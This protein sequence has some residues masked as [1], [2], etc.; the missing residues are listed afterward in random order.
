MALKVSSLARAVITR[1][2]S[3][4]QHGAHDDNRPSQP[5]LPV[6]PSSPPAARKSGAGQPGLPGIRDGLPRLGA[7]DAEAL[8]GLTTQLRGLLQERELTAGEILLRSGQ[9]EASA[10]G[11]Y[12]PE[13]A[14]DPIAVVLRACA[15]RNRSQRWSLWTTAV[16]AAL[17]AASPDGPIALLPSIAPA[18]TCR[19]RPK[20][21]AS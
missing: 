6:A 21:S 13:V 20:K 9:Y 15:T 5:A 10:L 11:E 16:R 17:R 18:R 1:R 19:L 7:S 14:F 2:G 12:I 4:L 8:S 3:S